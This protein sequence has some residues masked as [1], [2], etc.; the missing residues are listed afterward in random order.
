MHYACAGPVK[1][2]ACKRFTLLKIYFNPNVETYV[3][4]KNICVEHI[5]REF[6]NHHGYVFSDRLTLTGSPLIE[7][8]MDSCCKTITMFLFFSLPV[9]NPFFQARSQQPLFLSCKIVTFFC[10][11]RARLQRHFRWRAWRDQ[12]TEP[13]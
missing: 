9:K 7:W 6:Q 13:S 10:L 5:K 2:I 11:F 12:I 1:T 4:L 8:V 3:T